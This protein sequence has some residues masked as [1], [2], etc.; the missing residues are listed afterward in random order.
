VAE[1]GFV[2][3]EWDYLKGYTVKMITQETIEKMIYIIRDGVKVI[4]DRDL[5]RLYGVETKQL[6][7][8]VRR[9]IDRFP[10]DFLIT[11]TRKEYASLRCQNG[12]L[13]K[14]KHSKYLP[15]A[16]TELGVAMLSSVLNSKTAVHINI[17]IMRVFVRLRHLIDTHRE[18]AQKIS[19]LERKSDR[20]DFQIQK[21]FDTVRAIPL[22]PEEK[23]AKVKGFVKE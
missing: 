23:T 6:K 18:I 15:Y 4:L 1:H 3:P 13:E 5:A 11:L 8:Q 19:Q 9:N 2:V 16:F 20:H 22:L 17:S 14:G 10:E 12:T 7:R 21:L